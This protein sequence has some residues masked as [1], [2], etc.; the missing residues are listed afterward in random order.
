MRVSK[1]LNA[2]PFRN[3]WGSQD[4]QFVYVKCLHKVQTISRVGHVVPSFFGWI[5]ILVEK[6]P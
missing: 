2:V 3:N 5:I 1:K 6:V 4:F